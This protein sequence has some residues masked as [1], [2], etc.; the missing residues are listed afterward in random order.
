MERKTNIYCQLKDTNNYLEVLADWSF[1]HCS[2]LCSNLRKGSFNSQEPGR[3]ERKCNRLIFCSV[4]RHTTK[5]KKHKPCSSTCSLAKQ[6]LEIKSAVVAIHLC[7]VRHENVSRLSLQSSTCLTSLWL[8]GKN[9]ILET[10]LNSLEFLNLAFFVRVWQTLQSTCF[11]LKR[12]YFGQVFSI[13]LCFFLLKKASVW[14]CTCLQQN[15]CS[16]SMTLKVVH[17]PINPHLHEQKGYKLM[18]YMHTTAIRTLDFL[19]YLCNTTQCK[20]LSSGNTDSLTCQLQGIS[21]LFLETNA[22]N[23]LCNYLLIT[24]AGIEIPVYM[25]LHRAKINQKLSKAASYE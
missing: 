21:V 11:T 13:S 9:I 23:N 20:I 14:K 15:L 22:H 24:W 4:I 16:L 3:G 25:C 5:G 10:K 18:V 8:K 7:V 17:K 19:C 1:S 12:S 2:E 6:F